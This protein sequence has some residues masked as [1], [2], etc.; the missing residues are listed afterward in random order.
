MRIGLLRAESGLRDGPDLYVCQ[1]R[2]L[3]GRFHPDSYPNRFARVL[4]PSPGTN[5][6]VRLSSRTPMVQRMEQ[7][8]EGPVSKANRDPNKWRLCRNTQIKDDPLFDY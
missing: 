4:K 6:T 3:T 8:S 2:A 7:T 1:L 5:G